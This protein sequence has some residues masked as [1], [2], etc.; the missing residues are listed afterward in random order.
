M[1]DERKGYTKLRLY[2]K[3]G[4]SA[5][6]GKRCGAEPGKNELPFLFN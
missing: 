5:G 1:E 2:N 4:S 6:P 3:K